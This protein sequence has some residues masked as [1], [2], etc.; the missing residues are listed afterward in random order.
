MEAFGGMLGTHT[1]TVPSL[2]DHVT[3][4]NGDVRVIEIYAFTASLSSSSE[5]ERER[6]RVKPSLKTSLKT[7][8][9]K[10]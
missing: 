5:P 4:K 7:W 9:S 2:L 8:K 1:H 6:E 10:H 3:V